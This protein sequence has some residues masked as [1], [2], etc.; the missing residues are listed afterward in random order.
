[1]TIQSS[2]LIRCSLPATG[3]ATH[4]KAYYIQHIQTGAEC[5]SGTLAEL[6]QWMADQNLRYLADMIAQAG[7]ES[8]EEAR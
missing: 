8:P 4:G 6:T 3:E 7:V 2:F 5:R 1:M